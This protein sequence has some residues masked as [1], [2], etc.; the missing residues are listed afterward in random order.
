LFISQ[1]CE[2][3]HYQALALKAHANIIKAIEIPDEEAVFNAMKIL[4]PEAKEHAL[5]FFENKFKHTK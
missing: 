5:S 2:Y 1:T 4:L 3:Q